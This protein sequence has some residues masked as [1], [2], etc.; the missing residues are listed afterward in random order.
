[1]ADRAGA[2]EGLEVFLREDL[3]DKTHSLVYAE[4]FAVAAARCDTRALLTAVLKGEE[5]VVGQHGRILVAV[6]GED[7]AFMLGTVGLG[8]GNRGEVW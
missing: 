5:T 1:M 7:A 4:R 2:L 3:R 8:Q 6:S